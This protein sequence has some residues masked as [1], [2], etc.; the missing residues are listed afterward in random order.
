MSEQQGRRFN[1]Y[2]TDATHGIIGTL[3]VWNILT[4]IVAF[5]LG[6]ELARRITVGPMQTFIAFGCVALAFVLTM[7]LRRLFEAKPKYLWHGWEFWSGEDLNTVA[8]D[9]RPVPLISLGGETGG[10]K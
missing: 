1:G 10:E 9:R 7:V 8:P 3:T 5:V 4:L 6:L 2:R